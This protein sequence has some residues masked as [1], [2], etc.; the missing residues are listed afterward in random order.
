MLG[1]AIRML[2]RRVLRRAMSRA[3]SSADMEKL[4]APFV[5]GAGANGVGADVANEVFRQIAA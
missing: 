3:R 2:V 1:L 5:D 4:R